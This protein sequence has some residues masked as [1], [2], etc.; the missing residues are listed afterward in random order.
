MKYD[1]T[2]A[3]ELTHKLEAEGRYPHPDLISAIWERRPESEPLL[4]VMFGEAYMV[5][6]R[7]VPLWPGGHS[8]FAAGAGKREWWGVALR[9]WFKA[10]LPS[11]GS[12]SI[13]QIPAMRW[14]L[15]CV[16]NYHRWK[17]SPI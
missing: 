10:A 1:D 12:P 5:R 15:F 6:G 2:S 9:P 17:L 11:P 14:P 8:N 4:S 7:S 3:E 13:T 16:P